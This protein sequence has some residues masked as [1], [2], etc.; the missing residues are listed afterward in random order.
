MDIP[1]HPRLGLLPTPLIPPI[2][3]VVPPAS[4]K[5]KRP[6]SCI[7]QPSEVSSVPP[8]TKEKKKPVLI[9]P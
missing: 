5:G 2:Y 4:Y 7:S 3:V 8:P 6:T 9:D 1:P